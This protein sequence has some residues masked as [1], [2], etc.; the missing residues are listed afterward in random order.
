MQSKVNVETTDTDECV[1]MDIFCCY[2][3]EVLL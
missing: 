3:A 2:R 1:A